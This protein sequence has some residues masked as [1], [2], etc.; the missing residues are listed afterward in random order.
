MCV[1]VS[2]CVSVRVHEQLR[3]CVQHQDVLKR[4]PHIA[5]YETAK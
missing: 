1:C 3:V 5:V 4:L 2:A